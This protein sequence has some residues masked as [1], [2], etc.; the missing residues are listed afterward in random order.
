MLA[1]GRFA[2]MPQHRRDLEKSA[3]AAGP[4]TEGKHTCLWYSAGIVWQS[5]NHVGGVTVAAA[6]AAGPWTEGMYVLFIVD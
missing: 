6:A 3:A 2:F 4:K 1:V 5:G